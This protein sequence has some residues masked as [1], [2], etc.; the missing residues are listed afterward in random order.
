MLCYAPPREHLGLPNRWD[1]K[2]GDI[3]Y[4]IADL[5]IGHPGTQ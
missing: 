5:A 1:V 2:V 4:Q 3:T